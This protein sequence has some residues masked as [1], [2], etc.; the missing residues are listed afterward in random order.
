MFC[1]SQEIGWEDRLTYCVLSWTLNLTEV[2][3]ELLNCLP[4]KRIFQ[5][6]ARVCQVSK[7]VY[8][9]FIGNAMVYC[10]V[11]GGGMCRWN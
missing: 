2:T 5:H 9:L 1:T 3:Y 8:D 11:L 6:K 10:S 7:A 4:I